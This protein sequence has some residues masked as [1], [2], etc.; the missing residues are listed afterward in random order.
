MSIFLSQQGARDVRRLLN[1]W[2]EIDALV[3]GLLSSP[4]LRE[5]RTNQWE[6]SATHLPSQT[7]ML[8]KYD[9]PLLR[10]SYGNHPVAYGTVEVVAFRLAEYKPVA[11]SQ[12]PTEEPT[13][14][15]EQSPAAGQSP[16]YDQSL[17]LKW[18][19]ERSGVRSLPWPPSETFRQCLV[20][21][22]VGLDGTECWLTDAG[23]EV[24]RRRNSGLGTGPDP[25]K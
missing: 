14:T 19:D 16:T 7:T 4:C 10:V 20:Q 2:A 17:M 6:F 23:E 3:N 8:F 15:E 12:S 22:W 1:A 9:G 5:D 25:A 24:V 21:G 11:T 18:L 13:P